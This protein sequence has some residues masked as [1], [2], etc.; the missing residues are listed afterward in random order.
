MMTKKGRGWKKLVQMLIKACADERT[1]PPRSA[2][3]GQ[4]LPGLPMNVVQTGEL[5]NRLACSAM[6]AACEVQYD[7]TGK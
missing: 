5:M 6:P 7:N 3:G 2:V 4:N 1:C